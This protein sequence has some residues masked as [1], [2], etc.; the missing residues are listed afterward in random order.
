MIPG[1]IDS[2]CTLAE[3]CSVKALPRVGRFALRTEVIEERKI[4]A[5]LRETFT[6]V[7]LTGN[8]GSVHV[9]TVLMPPAAPRKC[10]RRLFFE[11]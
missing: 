2:V 6:G 5:D 10:G 7:S 11:T 1:E 3:T 9:M 4:V 8:A